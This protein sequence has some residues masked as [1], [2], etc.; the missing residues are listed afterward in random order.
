M[1]RKRPVAEW[2]AQLP[3]WLTRIRRVTSGEHCEDLPDREPSAAHDR[4]GSEYIRIDG[5]AAQKISGFHDAGSAAVL[6]RQC[7]ARWTA[8]P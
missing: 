6:T 4:L 7:Y 3:S 5:D 1:L 8:T 2:G